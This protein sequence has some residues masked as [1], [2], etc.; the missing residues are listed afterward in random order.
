MVYRP[1]LRRR[2]TNASLS[3]LMAISALL[4]VLSGHAAAAGLALDKQVSVHAASG[5]SATTAAFTTAQASELLVAFISIDGPSGTAKQTVSGVTGG[6][7]TWTLRQR[8][9]AQ[10][11]TAEIWTASASSILTNATVKATH[12]ASYASSLTV[13]TF[14]GAAVGAVAGASATTGAPTVSLTTTKAGSWV[15]AAGTDWDR[16]QAHTV[17]ALQT[18]VDEYLAPVGDTYWVQRQTNLTPAVGTVVASNDTAPTNDRWN[19]AAIEIVPVVTDTVAPTVPQGVVA[20]AVSYNQV[21]V[22]WNASTDDSGVAPGYKVFRDGTQ[23]ATGTATNFTDNTVA[24]N[25]SYNYTVQAY[26]AAG[27]VSAAS[28]AASV[29]TPANTTP[30]VI[31]SVNATSVTSSGAAITWTTDKTTSSQVNYGTTDTYGAATVLDSALVTAH[32]QALTGLAA[33]TTYHYQVVSVDANG[34][35]AS[36]PDATFTTVAVDATAPTVQ[37]TSPADTATVAGSVV[38][39]ATASDNVGVT[40]VQ[41]LLDGNNLGAPVATAPYSVTWNSATVS[42]GSHT[43]AARASDAAGN[44][45]VSSVTVTVNNQAGLAPTVDASTPA[46]K[47]VLNNVPSTTSPSFSP[48]AGSVIYAV[49]SM[50][51]ASYSGTITTVSSITTTGDPI[52]WHLLGRNNAFSSTAGGFLEVWWAYN[53][54]AQTNITSTATFSMN[55]K[56]VAPPVGDFQIIVMNNAAPDQSAAAWTNNAL[57]TSLGNTPSASVTTT[58][59]NS[60]VFG[61]FNNWNNAQTPVAGANQT[62]TSIVLNPTD[63]DGYWIQKQNAPT[64]AAGTSVLMN[65]TDPGQANEWRALAW[66]VLA[67]N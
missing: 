36:S 46:A 27:N 10:A 43:L 3:V 47:A 50:D 34:N 33:D 66:E 12:A 21:A 13:A 44:T 35:S 7:L 9:N 32:S 31:S 30:P 40:G 24:A 29:T 5:T 11:G 22:G 65:A 8:V 4:P 42:N 2:V 63:V 39:T 61:V 56:N 16:A 62:I 6:G 53:P 52:I 19:F 23:V 55:T 38:V 20:N 41:F 45:T 59:A 26:D 25:T 14:P 67:A 49:L 58:R 51:S 57:L 18:K 28:A 15:W 1:G 60:L 17:G 54:T 64:A 48:P 37:V